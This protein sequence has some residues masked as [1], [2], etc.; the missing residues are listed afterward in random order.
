MR[1]LLRLQGR[2]QQLDMGSV[3]MRARLDSGIFGLAV[4]IRPTLRLGKVGKANGFGTTAIAD[5][6]SGMDS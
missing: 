5:A 3:V 1:S 2:L 4:E 6:G